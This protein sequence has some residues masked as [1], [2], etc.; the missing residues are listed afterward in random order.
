MIA[1]NKGGNPEVVQHNINGLLVPYID[2]DALTAAFDHAFTPG[3]RA[4]L[5][6]H[7]W[8]DDRFRMDRMARQTEAVL[9]EIANV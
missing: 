9:K 2:P 1:S 4:S 8:L 7:A 5:A 3:V 6:A